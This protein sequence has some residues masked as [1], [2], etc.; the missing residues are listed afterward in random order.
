[1]TTPT[2]YHIMPSE[3][4]CYN[5]R[6]VMGSAASQMALALKQ[7]TSVKFRAAGYYPVGRSTWHPVLNQ[8]IK[9]SYYL[10]I[11]NLAKGAT[12]EH[13]LF[14]FSQPTSE[15][16]ALELVYGPTQR[17]DSDPQILVELYEIS[18]GAVGTKIDD[19]ILF[20][21]PDHLQRTYTGEALGV[22]SPDHLQRTYTGEALGAYRC[23]TGARPYVATAT[24]TYPTLPRPLYV[25]S[26]NRGDELVIRVTAEDAV[27]YGVYIFDIYTGA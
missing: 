16:I 14:Y 1:M 15:Y 5:G 24:T 25:P 7:L 12:D 20:S 17:A 3:E 23:N 11:G 10:G 13:D 4:G 18:G 19:G 2:N 26:A 8:Y 21:S 6:I 22:S 9:A 27:L